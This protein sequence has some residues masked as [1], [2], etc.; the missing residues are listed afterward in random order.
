[1]LD[2]RARQSKQLASMSNSTVSSTA[3]S[4][5]S[6]C[7]LILHDTPPGVIP[8]ILLAHMTSRFRFRVN[9]SCIEQLGRFNDHV[10]PED[11]S[12]T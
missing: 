6:Y 7:S 3:G 11:E 9:Y 1:M 12:S 8:E 4:S 5:F 10:S 2:A